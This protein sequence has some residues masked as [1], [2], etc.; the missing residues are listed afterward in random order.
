MSNRKTKDACNTG[1]SFQRKTVRCYSPTKRVRILWRRRYTKLMN[2]LILTSVVM[3]WSLVLSAYG[4]NH[5][6]FIEVPSV[7][8]VRVAAISFVPKKFDLDGNTDRLTLAFREAAQGGAR[9]AVGPEGALE[10]YVVNDIIAGDATAERM[11]QVAIPIDSPTIKHFQALARKLCLC[12]VFGFAELVDE[13]I[14]NSAV[15]VDQT[16]KICGKYHKMQLAEGYHSSWWF[17]RL[18]TTSGAFDTPFG[19]CGVLICND[20][21]NPQLA[22]IPAFDGAQFLVIPSFGSR[23]KKQDEAVLS[24][25]RETGLPIIEANVG[26]SLIVDDGEIVAVDRCEEGITFSTISIPSSKSVDAAARDKVQS[27]FLA[28][29]ADEMV[30]RYHKT[31]ERYQK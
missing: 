12:L 24:R 11:R 1:F 23:S 3:T 15:F 7:T 30:R 2:Q 25:G 18:G 6:R 28:W 22:Q 13:D 19:R 17:N 20:R 5:P 27:E 26:V 29:R 10:G 8:K 16:G 21:W 9:I 14:F 4:Q 31:L